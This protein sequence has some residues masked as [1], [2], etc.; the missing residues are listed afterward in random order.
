MHTK[1]LS[2]FPPSRVRSLMNSSFLYFITFSVATGML[3]TRAKQSAISAFELVNSGLARGPP[4]VGAPPQI[5]LGL[6]P[7]DLLLNGVWV[8]PQRGSGGGA[9]SNI[10]SAKPPLCLAPSGYATV[11]WPTFD[12]A[13]K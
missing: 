10:L 12:K 7:P 1:R 13:N 2:N 5:P 9:P 3:L 8:E 11:L 4:A 6:P